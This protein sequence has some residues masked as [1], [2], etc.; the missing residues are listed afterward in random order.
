MTALHQKKNKSI[1]F[2]EKELRK[3][4]NFREDE[5]FQFYFDFTTHFNKFM[6]YINIYKDL[7]PNQK[8][9]AQS[10][11]TLLLNKFK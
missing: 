3:Y 7:Q 9:V 1:T 11:I 5:D 2:T 4:F 10:L 6:E 8:R